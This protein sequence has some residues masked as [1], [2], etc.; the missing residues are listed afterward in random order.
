MLARAS[1]D[2]NRCGNGIVG[3]S[4]HLNR[5]AR[6]TQHRHSDENR[7]L[8]LS[9]QLNRPA[10]ASQH[11]QSGEN[12]ILR[13]SWPLNR[14]A[15]ASQDLHC[16]ENGFVPA[17]KQASTTSTSSKI[18]FSI[19]ASSQISLHELHKASTVVEMALSDHP[20]T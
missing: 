6:V 2:F 10:R 11:F 18:A 13:L 20:G 8:D 19:F 7:F 14:P 15:S 5:L 1:Q 4:R 9:S 16:G 17:L 12:C 3:P